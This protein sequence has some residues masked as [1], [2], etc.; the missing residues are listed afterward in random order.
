M[1]ADV[2]R[3]RDTG[4]GNQSPRVHANA[5][6]I[7][8]AQCR[9]VEG[10]ASAQLLRQIRKRRAAVAVQRSAQPAAQQCDPVGLLSGSGVA[11]D[12]TITERWNE[13]AAADVAGGSVPEAQD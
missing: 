6:R 13:N 4:V 12:L 10:A 5:H 11:G 2:F 9:C 3:C 8:G 7:A 1:Q